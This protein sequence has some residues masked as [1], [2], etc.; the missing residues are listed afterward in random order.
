M[1]KIFLLVLLLLAGCILQDP[2]DKVTNTGDEGISVHFVEEQNDQVYDDSPLEIVSEFRNMGRYD[3]PFG[4]VVL[5][6]YDSS[7]LQ[8]DSQKQGYAEKQLPKLNAKTT[9]TPEGGYNTLAFKATEENL[10]VRDG[11][12]YDTEIILATCYHYKTFLT[13]EV[14][15]GNGGP[16]KS[17]PKTFGGQGA[18]VAI[19]RIEQEM[20]SN[21]LNIIATIE[22]VGKGKVIAPEKSS[23]EACPFSLQEENTNRVK[24]KM[25]INGLTKESCSDSGLLTLTKGRG[26]VHCTF[27]KDS[28]DEGGY[29]TQLQVEADYYYLNS[30]RR[31]IT[32][33]ST[34]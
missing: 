7:I 23:Y 17:G 1:K 18:P 4:K 24:I 28:N 11:D 16:C 5:Y 13:Q 31:D 30:D 19:T 22:N 32:I 8:F 2:Q 15:V 33:L 34:P 21:K 27:S 14:C 3:Q 20:I 9:Y 12:K 26:K 6:G 10:E 29:T 25:S